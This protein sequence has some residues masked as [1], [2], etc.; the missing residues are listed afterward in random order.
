L[1]LMRVT[2]LVIVCGLSLPLLAQDA[3]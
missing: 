3:S 1:W 2:A